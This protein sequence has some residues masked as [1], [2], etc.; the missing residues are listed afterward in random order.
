M[1]TDSPILWPWPNSWMLSVRGKGTELGGGVS[2]KEP[3]QAGQERS[4]GIVGFCFRE[5]RCPGSAGN[6][7]ASQATFLGFP[8]SDGQAQGVGISRSE[9]KHLPAAA[10]LRAKLDRGSLGPCLGVVTSLWSTERELYFT[11]KLHHYRGCHT[12]ILNHLIM[13]HHA[14]TL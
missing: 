1:A 11:T 13:R 4:K 9:W 12:T 7:G 10:S 2:D 14:A 3:G 5:G 8:R 6:V